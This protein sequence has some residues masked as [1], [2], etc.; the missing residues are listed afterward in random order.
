M[1]IRMMTMMMTV[2]TS[3]RIVNCETPPTLAHVRRNVVRMCH[4]TSGPR[5][6]RR[7]SQ[8]ILIGSQWIFLLPAIHSRIDDRHLIFRIEQNVLATLVGRID[9]LERHPARGRDAYVGQEPVPIFVRHQMVLKHARLL[10]IQ[11]QRSRIAVRTGSVRRGD[12]SRTNMAQCR[13]PNAQLYE[14]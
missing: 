1:A 3:A 10:L 8:Q 12:R 11:R 5:E 4:V 6:A 9:E 14:E 7:E 2:S 13:R